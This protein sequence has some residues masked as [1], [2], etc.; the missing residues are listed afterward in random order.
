M[1]HTF[2]Q[3]VVPDI[4][5]DAGTFDTPIVDE[6]G[7][8]LSREE[9]ESIIGQLASTAEAKA[10]LSTKSD[11]YLKARL[12]IAAEQAA[13][14]KNSSP[15][16]EIRVMGA[17][18]LRNDAAMAAASAEAAY[19]KNVDSLNDWRNQPVERHDAA[20]PI[21]APTPVPSTG[22][23]AL[24]AEAAYRQSVNNLNAWRNER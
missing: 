18:A 11:V 21:P 12:E 23:D 4:R 24:D 5:W 20:T 13:L 1:V 9:R 3:D 6:N 14:A 10:A 17:A 16:I 8:G 22:N 19:R 2:R 15:S 7:H